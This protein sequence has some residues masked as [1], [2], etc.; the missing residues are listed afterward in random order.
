M[1]RLILGTALALT[2]ASTAFAG[3]MDDAL[4]DPEPIAP[5]APVV[6]ANDWTGGYAGLTFGQISTDLGGAQETGPIFGGFVGYDYDFG[7]F[8][9]GGEFDYQ[10]T[11][12]LTVGG[13]DIDSIARLKMRAGYDMGPALVYFTAGGA[14][15]DTSLGTSS[16]YVA[17]IGMDY[18]VTD[19]FTVG[20]E[21]LAHEFN[22]VGSTNTDLSANTFALRGA[23][24]F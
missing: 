6:V 10:A 11:D 20:G 9:L 24:R 18:A 22:D 21:F 12:D 5:V 8:V 23:F 13:V 14:Q 16:G 1:N 17:G 4:V 3:S 19:N 15:A 7:N 2:T